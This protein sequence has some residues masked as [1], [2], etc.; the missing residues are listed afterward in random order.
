M[1][2]TGQGHIEEFSETKTTP[3]RF[4]RWSNYFIFLLLEFFMDF[5]VGVEKI[6]QFSLNATFCYSFVTF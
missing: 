4:K 1:P 2:K 5:S 6:S 3:K